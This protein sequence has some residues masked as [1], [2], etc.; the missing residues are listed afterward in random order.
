MN[1]K[2]EQAAMK[3]MSGVELTKL[4]RLA[5]TDEGKRVQ[6]M[7]K[8]SNIEQAAENGDMESLKGAVAQLLQTEAGAKLAKQISEMM[9]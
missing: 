1:E 6:E 4:K 3:M 8:N 9:K 2:L 5:S 7:L